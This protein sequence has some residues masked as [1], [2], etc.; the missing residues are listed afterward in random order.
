M[1]RS[2]HARLPEWLTSNGLDFEQRDS[3]ELNTY[4]CHASHQSG[5]FPFVIQSHAEWIRLSAPV[6]K[7]PTSADLSSSHWRIESAQLTTPI[8]G[9]TT[10]FDDQTVFISRD[11]LWRDVKTASALADRVQ[12]FARA[13]EYL[14]LRLVGELESGGFDRTAELADLIDATHPPLWNPPDWS[15]SH[16]DWSVDLWLE[17]AS[18]STRHLPRVPDGDDRTLLPIQLACLTLVASLPRR[19]M[20][21]VS[22]QLSLLRS[23]SS[24]SS[25]R[26]E[27]YVSRILTLME[28]E[29]E[30]GLVRSQEDITR[31][32]QILLMPH[33]G[34][35]ADLAKF[36][37]GGD[38]LSST[39]SS[40]SELTNLAMLDLD[41]NRLSSAPSDLRLADLPL[42]DLHCNLLMDS[43]L[44]EELTLE[45]RTT[46]EPHAPAGTGSWSKGTRTHGHREADVISALEALS[47]P[48]FDSAD[49]STYLVTGVAGVGKT[50]LV[51]RLAARARE[52]SFKLIRFDALDDSAAFGPLLTSLSAFPGEAAVAIDS[53]RHSPSLARTR[54]QA[55]VLDR[56]ERLAR[57]DPILIVIDDCQWIDTETS[58]LIQRLA[59]WDL[60]GLSIVIC[61]REG[62][63]SDSPWLHLRSSLRRSHRVAEVQIVPLDQEAMRRF[64]RQKRPELSET[65]TEYVCHTLLDLTGG[66]PALADNALSQMSDPRDLLRLNFFSIADQL[67][68]T[69]LDDLSQAALETG[70]RCAALAVDFTREDLEYAGQVEWDMDDA[71]DELYWR[72]LLVESTSAS[73]VRLTNAAVRDAFLGRSALFRRRRLYQMAA[74]HFRDNVHRSAWLQALALPLA[75]QSSTAAAL[76][77]SA[78]RY[79]EDEAYWDA[80]CRYRWSMELDESRLSSVDKRYLVHAEQL[81]GVD[82]S[83]NVG[84]DGKWH[85]AALDASEIMPF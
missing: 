53:L 15:S 54:L 61:G 12:F 64:V 50:T 62:A 40:L 36:G 4:V 74:R 22:A 39:E 77:Q 30:R 2:R 67:L 43:D 66:V 11:E 59:H 63:K 44:E 42:A 69:S 23:H 6:A 16:K 28:S 75:S 60:S 13:H 72:G 33:H 32:L 9:F 14:T 85:Q 21:E 18:S 48:V 38:P 41:S 57:N 37:L 84:A 68:E 49:S 80:V 20:R 45:S 26:S 24:D 17:Y 52:Q 82:R 70:I 25:Q 7:L 27:D 83:S 65:V 73:H 3:E 10:I 79:Y 55:D 5:A 29:V 71:L 46:S 35:T 56:I 31:E 51:S 78:A 76:A 19:S 34:G 58:S 1:T 8:A 47:G 81:C